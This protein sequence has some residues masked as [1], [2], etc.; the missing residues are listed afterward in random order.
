MTVLTLLMDILTLLRNGA[1][2]VGSER[3]TAEF[4]E[5]CLE[6]AYLRASQDLTPA[7]AALDIVPE[8]NQHLNNLI[9]V[10]AMMQKKIIT[11]KD[12]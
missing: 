2:V 8:N 5:L 7:L 3:H 4:R 6:Q 9:D 1:T 10:S 12:P 11:R